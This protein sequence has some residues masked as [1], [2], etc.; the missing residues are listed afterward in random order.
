M[1]EH[2]NKFSSSY[3]S[4]LLISAV[5]GLSACAHKN[6]NTMHDGETVINDPY[7]NYNRKVMAFNQ[8]VDKS[9]IY[10]S[11]RGYRTVVPA[12]AR[13][14]IQNVLRNLG[15]PVTLANQILQGDFGGA[16]D[17]I[18]RAIVNTTIGLGGIF[19]VA[20]YEGI[21]YEQEDFGQTLAVWG[22]DYG[23]YFVVP[24]LGPSSLRDYGGY[25]VDSMVD[26][27]GWYLSNTD[28]TDIAAAKFSAGYLN[29]RD[30]LMDSQIDLSQSSFDYYA[31]VRSTYY[32]YRAAAIDDRSGTSLE[33]IPDIPD[34]DEYE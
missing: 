14:G 29:I 32:Q 16:H 3:K 23:P 21:K 19:D 13:T 12:P 31:A 33:T 4:I 1:Y 7:E 25:F 20:G 22:V 8:V 28:K 18:I 17:A 24:L 30:T 34:Y 9:V 10:P 11:I 2:L 27:L 6:D 26:P 5:L 15:S